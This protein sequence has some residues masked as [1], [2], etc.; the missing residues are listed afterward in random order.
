M[1]ESSDPSRLTAM[2]L[3]KLALP[4]LVI[5]CWFAATTYLSIHP[6][7]LPK[8]QSV[9]R[10]FFLYVGN[11]ELLTHLAVSLRRCLIGLTGGAFL[12][13]ALGVLL[14]WNRC[15]ED[16][17][18]IGVNFTR[19]IPKTALAPLF[20]V[21]FGFE[22]LPKVLLIGLTTFFYTLIP[23]MEG[24]KNV[25]RLYLKSARSLG[26]GDLQILVSVV[27]PA[28]LPAMYAGVRLAAATAL[29]ILVFVEILCGNS[30]LG[31]L[32]EMSR[33][34]LNTSTMYMTLLVLGVLG[35]LLDWLV[36]RSETWLMPWQKG[37]T[38]SS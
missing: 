24:V 16:I 35:F 37:R 8:L 20:I 5:G 2:L 25:D 4:L 33:A 11:G 26:A 12:G 7:I 6:L 14:G 36:R 3:R 28:A 34:S 21:W 13:I 1:S 30:G 18:D 9:V 29:V 22:E 17:F 38:I 15:L 19:A 32:L 27:I 10:D 31:Y 23:T